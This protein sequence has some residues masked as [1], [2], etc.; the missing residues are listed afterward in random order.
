MVK[1]AVEYRC[2]WPNVQRQ[3][4]RTDPGESPV[5]N[6]EVGTKSGTHLLSL[7]YS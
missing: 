3:S 4:E 1:E 7:Y 6:C 2:S 5:G